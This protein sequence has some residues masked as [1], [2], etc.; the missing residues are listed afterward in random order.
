MLR[1]SKV[2]NRALL[3]TLKVLE[4]PSIVAFTDDSET[5]VGQSAKRQALTNPK[6]TLYAIKRPI[7][8]RFEDNVVQKDIKMVPYT[9]AKARITVTHGRC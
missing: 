3:K 2:T 8:R 5:L 9:I 4:P 7:G 1:F 6:N